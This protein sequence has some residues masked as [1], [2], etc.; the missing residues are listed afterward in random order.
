MT[1][2]YTFTVNHSQIRLDQYLVQK[3]SGYS[4]SKIQNHIKLGQVTIDGKIGKSSLILHGNE[5]VECQ[6][7]PEP[8]NESITPEPMNLDIMYEDD[9]LAVINK[10]AGIVIHPGNG[11]HTGTLLNGLL[12]HF[13]VLSHEETTRPGII[14]RLDKDTTGVLLVAKNNKSHDSLSEQ[15]SQRLVKKKYLALVWGELK[16]RGH[17]EG[18]ISRHPRKRQT[19][20][21]V[22]HGGRDSI[23]RFE[24]EKYLPPLSLVKL[25]PETGRTHQLRVHLKSICH[26]IFGDETYGGGVKYAK[27]FHVKYT[28]LIKRLMRT[29]QRVALHAR[30]LEIIHPETGDKM[31]FE[32]PLPIDFKTALDC[33]ENEQL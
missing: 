8:L 10:S 27:S 25:F 19:F 4:R 5:K 26:P 29:I 16:E 7:D 33:L 9:H 11:N 1:N 15:F 17:I 3:L 30:K 6:F 31:S 28:Q 32:A 24:L 18:A 20:T 13:K 23:T 2:Y 12:H 21:I 14:H 22:E